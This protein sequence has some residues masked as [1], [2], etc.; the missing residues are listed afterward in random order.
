MEVKQTAHRRTCC[1]AGVPASSNVTTS[2]TGQH[3]FQLGGIFAVGW[4]K[5]FFSVPL[6]FFFL[7][8]F[9]ISFTFCTFISISFMFSSF[10]TLQ[11]T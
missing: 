1:E 11:L 5:Y 2:L 6:T 7:F 8:L 3:L 10:M 9:S 4:I